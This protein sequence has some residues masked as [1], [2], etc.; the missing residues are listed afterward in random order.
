[1]GEGEIMNWRICFMVSMATMVFLV[2]NGCRHHFKN[3]ESLQGATKQQ[4]IDA[5]GEP[6]SKAAAIF[7]KIEDGGVRPLDAFLKE[8]QKYEQWGYKDNYG[9][10]HLLFFC[11]PADTQS[12]SSQWKVVYITIQ[13][14]NV[15][16]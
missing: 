5:L 6:D 12:D 10:T 14:A 4:V 2:A 8:G 1:M 13:E 11:D 15:L 9:D 7:L 3:V 16:Y